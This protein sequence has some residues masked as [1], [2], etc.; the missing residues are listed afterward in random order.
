VF[1]DES[2]RTWLVWQRYQTILLKEGRHEEGIVRKED[3]RDHGTK[4]DA[5]NPELLPRHPL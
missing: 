2:K 1:A 4:K 5:K 3:G